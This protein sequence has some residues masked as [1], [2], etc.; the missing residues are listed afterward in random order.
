[1]LGIGTPFPYFFIDLHTW[2]KFGSFGVA[3]YL[4]YFKIPRQ[5][6]IC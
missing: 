4:G 1:M 5:L 2:E 3:G 6:H